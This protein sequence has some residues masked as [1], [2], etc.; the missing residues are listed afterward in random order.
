MCLACPQQER[1]VA[2]RE[3][4]QHELPTPRPKK[5]RPARLAYALILHDAPGTVL[6]EQRPSSGLWGG[7]WTLPQ[8]DTQDAALAWATQ[9]FGIGLAS[10]R[11]LAP[12]EHTFTHFDLT[13]HPLIVKVD[14]PVNAIA[15]PNTHVWYDTRNPLRIGLAKPAVDLLRIVQAECIPASESATAVTRKS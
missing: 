4:L 3:G 7:L 8:F 11:A 2:Y 12:Y 6:L 15:E 14:R 13:L 9:R 10:A 1:C 5:V